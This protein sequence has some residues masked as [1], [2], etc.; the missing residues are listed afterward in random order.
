[1]GRED[2]IVQ[3][4]EDQIS[5]YDDK[6]GWNQRWFRRLQVFIIVA[7]ALVPF[8]SGL[9][10]TA[11]VWDDAF[12]GVLGVLI[13]ALTAVL[14]LYKFQENWVQYRTTAESLKREKYIFLAGVH[15]YSGGD[16]F[17]LLV[18]RVEGLISSEHDNWAKQGIETVEKT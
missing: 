1:M 8:V 10:S 4:L 16:A 5:W 14:G 11:S 13:A 15:P 12:V 6:A 18:E 2:Y 17:E 7:G 9:G 3:R